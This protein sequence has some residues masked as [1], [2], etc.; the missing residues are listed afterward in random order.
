MTPSA[1]TPSRS[2]AARPDGIGSNSGR[3]TLRLKAGRSLSSQ[4][5]ATFHPRGP[6]SRSQ[7]RAAR[8]GIASSREI[9]V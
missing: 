4:T 1:T 3:R 9:R 5:L 2:P 6:A 7:S 8:E